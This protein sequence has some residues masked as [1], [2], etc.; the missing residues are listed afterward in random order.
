MRTCIIHSLN[1]DI[2]LIGHEEEINLY[3]QFHHNQFQNEESIDIDAM[4]ERMDLHG[5]FC[6]ATPK[7]LKGVI[8]SIFINAGLKKY[9]RCFTL[10]EYHKFMKI[11][12]KCNRETINIQ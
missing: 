4:V 12:K 11:V 5:L 8:E 3:L 6:R 2:L 10:K 7:S 1:V 9:E